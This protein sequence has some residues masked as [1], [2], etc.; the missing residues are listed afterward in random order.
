ML[1]MQMGLAN[2]RASIYLPQ[3]THMIDSR[4]DPF[5]GYYF[6]LI[7]I[8]SLISVCSAELRT[9]LFILPFVR[10]KILHRVFKVTL[11]YR[12]LKMQC[13][14]CPA[15][16]YPSQLNWHRRFHSSERR[17]DCGDCGLATT[18]FAHALTHALLEG[19]GLGSL[20]QV[21]P[22]RKA[23]TKIVQELPPVPCVIESQ[24]RISR[25]QDVEIHQEPLPKCKSEATVQSK[26][27]DSQANVSCLRCGK[28]TQNKC[29]RLIYHVLYCTKILPYAC[30]ACTKHFAR[31]ENV[32]RHQRS[33]CREARVLIVDKWVDEERA[34]EGLRSCFGV[35][36]T[37]WR[38]F[39]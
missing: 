26:A 11:A 10:K 7:G 19:H 17:W 2:R 5:F 27:A 16:L 32:Y 1:V 38:G 35:E 37:N 31:R 9:Q 30:G 14:S 23:G 24:E 34:K 13:E 29:Q 8:S 33:V 4:F 20:D 6:K 28:T 36:G 25:C 21:Q 15:L 12:R 3:N 18:N 39:A 22:E